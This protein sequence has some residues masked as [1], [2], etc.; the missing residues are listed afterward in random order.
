MS[1]D[2]AVMTSMIRVY[3]I[4]VVDTSSDVDEEEVSATNGELKVALLCVAFNLLGLL[5]CRRP[6]QERNGNY[7]HACDHTPLL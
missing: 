4:D 2:S 3:L 1:V 7:T 5:C 6:S